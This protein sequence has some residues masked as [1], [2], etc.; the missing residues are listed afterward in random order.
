MTA[1]IEIKQD[2]SA[3]FAYNQRN[4]DPWHLL[5]TPVDGN[6][7][8]EV[9]LHTVGADFTAYAGPVKS[10]GTFGEV[11]DP[12]RIMVLA[13][14]WLPGEDG[15]DHLVTQPLGVMGEGYQ[16]V[17]YAEVGEKALAVVGAAE[18]QA[19]VD[20]MGLLYG[21]KRFFAFIDLGDLYIDPNGINDKIERGLGVYTS[22]DG[23][24]A[25]TY[26]MS[27]IRWVCKNTINLGLATAKR[28]FRAK[29]TT[30]VKARMAEAQKV[31]GISTAW[32][33]T[34][35]R[36]A[37]QLLSVPFTP[38]LMD[39]VLNKVFPVPSGGTDRQERNVQDIHD[40][41]RRLF[42]TENNAG[43]FGSNGW[44]LYN[45]VGEY[46]DHVR[47]GKPEEKALASMQVGSWVDKKKAQTADL[48]LAAK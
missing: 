25:V 8:L 31:L 9:M 47:T 32:A 45:S 12:T 38:V 22:H 20:T 43:G 34:F 4:G 28:V 6:Q 41:V 37:E 35:R 7:S 30:S 42:L 15:E 17:Q 46:L 3:S 10:T 27:D 29:H 44:T 16:I 1:E 21:G 18:G 39:R 40:T 11:V 13:D 2:G 19:V 24:I 36:Q 5:G 23:T 26:A 48:I 14:R 33:E